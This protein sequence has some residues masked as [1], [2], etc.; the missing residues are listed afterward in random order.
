M[1]RSKFRNDK[2]LLEKMHSAGLDA[3]VAFS[4]ENLFYLSGAFMTIQEMIRDRLSAAGIT[5]DGRDF[6]ICD[7]NERSVAESEAWVGELRD[8]VE[9]QGN[10]LETLAALLRDYGLDRAVVG[11]E[12]RYLMAQYYEELQRLLPRARLVGCDEVLEQARAVKTP[13]HIEIIRRINCI[14]EEVIAQTFQETRRGETEKEMAFR[15]NGNLLKA[16]ADVVR[17]LILTA[18]DNARHA[19][20]Y[21]G[22]K[23]LQPGDIIRIDAGGLFQGHGSDIGRMGVVGEPSPAQRDHYR[24]HRESQRETALGL[25]PGTRVCDV[26]QNC[27]RAYAGHGVEYRRQHIGHSLSVL[28]GH[29]YPMLHPRNEAV[30]EENMVIALEPIFNDAAG[31][32]YTVE[33]I[34]RVAENPEIL[35]TATDTTELYRVN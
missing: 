6:F 21:P 14:T 26:Y 34:I 11:I 27:V 32:R 33:D 7:R 25:K 35:T 22:D 24:I 20:P 2:R 12:K 29:D 9:F 3:L 17:F 23:V 28:G 5:A 31:R 4:M 19:H 18:G 10:A 13:E 15:L 30:L 8:Y 16:G 1:P